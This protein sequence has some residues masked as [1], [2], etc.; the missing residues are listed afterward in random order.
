MRSALPVIAGALVGL[1][2][3]FAVDRLS[4]PEGPA[5]VEDTR[6]S[7]VHWNDRFP[8]VLLQTHEGETVRFYEDLIKGKT[9]ALNFFYCGCAKF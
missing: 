7:A 8:D 1:A 5:P 2:G 3:L 4:T 6:S 9:V